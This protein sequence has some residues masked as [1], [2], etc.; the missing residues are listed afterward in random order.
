MQKTNYDAEFLKIKS[1]L[2][3]TPSLLLHV[4]CAPCATYCLTQL[5]DCFDVTLYY[6]NDNIMPQAE[7]QK[8]LDE[9]HRLVEI[10]NR[11][12]AN[13]RPVKLVTRSYD[14][15]RFLQAAKGF[16]NQPEGGLRCTKC[17]ELRLGD[18]AD[19]AAQNGFD[20][21]ATTLTVSPYKNSQL[22]NEIGNR[23]Q[24]PNLKWLPTDFKKRDGYR[25][26]IRLC[27]QYGIYRQ[28][29]CG[30]SF[31]LAEQLSVQK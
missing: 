31:S 25:Q 18:A 30:C 11:N 16:E 3:N 14:V 28:H 17:F 9:L 8:R 7:W 5:T 6:S 26:S 10:V 21:F 2:T 22:L 20:Y 4:C 27:E 13:A 19:F 12:K 23:V 1:S 24:T 29:Y 15:Q